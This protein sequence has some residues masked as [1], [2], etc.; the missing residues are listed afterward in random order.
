MVEFMGRRTTAYRGVL[1][2]YLLILIL[3]SRDLPRRVTYT[4][5]LPV[6]ITEFCSS[7]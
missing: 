1:D 6:S 2:D 4:P 7:A 5:E 3:D